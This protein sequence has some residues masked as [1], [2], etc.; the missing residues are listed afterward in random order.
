MRKNITSCLLSIS[1]VQIAIGQSIDSITLKRIYSIRVETMNDNRINGILLSNNDSSVY[2]YPGTL[3]QLKDN[4]N[5]RTAVF[6]YPNIKEIKVKKKND[7]GLFKGMVIGAGIGLAPAILSGIFGE[8]EGGAYV[9]VITVPVGAI[10][11]AI[12]GASGKKKFRINGNKDNY[13]KFR[14]KVK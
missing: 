8:G 12:I 14:S 10:T 9:S 2:V 7:G 1:L 6:D 5:F 3:N 4:E 11:G 13:A